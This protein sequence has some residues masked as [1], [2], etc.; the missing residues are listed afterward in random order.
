MSQSEINAEIDQ[1]L[2]LV[3]KKLSMLPD[4]EE[5]V[6]ELRTHIWES[7]NKFAT[8]DNLPIE[9]AFRKALD[10][11]EDPE[12]LANRFYEESGYEYSSSDIQS[13]PSY[14]QNSSFAQ[15]FQNKSVVPERKLE[16]DKF[17][18]IT[19]MGF[20]ASMIIG[21]TLIAT[22]KDP[23]ISILGSL[24]Q[25]GAFL[26]FILYLYYRDDQTFKEQIAL[27]REKFEKEFANKN[28]GRKGKKRRKFVSDR[29]QILFIH[30]GGVLGA[31]FMFFVLILLT[32][33]SYIYVQPFF[34]DYWFSVGLIG[35]YIMIGS[36]MIYY[37]V[38][39]FLG[40][41]RGLRM[42]EVIINFLSAIIIFIL[43]FYYPFTIGKG[44]IEVAGSSLTDPD[45][46]TFLSTKID[47]YIRIIMGI[48][49]AVN[50]MK[51]I[52]GIFKFETWKA[53][54]TK[55]LLNV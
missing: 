34:N 51:A 54:D 41:V 5:I 46:I 48:V 9:Q 49:V 2:H 24:I 35:F 25:M 4:A 20:A 26:G 52:Y 23:V 33:V 12:I 19:I 28:K 38:Q 39:A 8:R 32:V 29:V 50:L 45:V 11:M 22:I 7:A 37:V 44:I 17:L 47:Y 14:S 43:I 15:S 18:I 40:K 30:I 27:L 6:Q 31:M 1:Y 13:T 55:S 36:Q 16:Q 42:L 53:K 3:R 21:G 10:Q